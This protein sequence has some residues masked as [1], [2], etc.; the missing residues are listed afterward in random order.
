MKITQRSVE[1]ATYQGGTDYRWD[2]EVTGFGLRLYPSGR[3]AYV[4]AYRVNGRKR[5]MVLGRHGAL[6]VAQ[7]R[8][9]AQEKLHSVSKGIDPSRERQAARQA[10]TVAELGER[11]LLDHAGPKKKLRSAEEDRRNWQLHVLPRLA[12]RKVAEVTREDVDKLHSAMRAAPYAANRV[13]ALLSKAFTLAEVWGWRPDGSNPCRHVE[14]FKEEKRERFLSPEEIG[15]LGD[16]LSAAD[17]QATESPTVVA[18]VRLL[19]FTGCRLSEILTLRWEHVDLGAACLRLPDSKTGRRI[20]YLSPPAREVLASLERAEGNPYVIEG[21][22]KGEHLV[23]LEKPWRRIRAQVGLEDVRLHDLR[24]TFASIGAG[25]GLSLPL[26]GKMLGHTQPATTA[27]YAHL[28][29]DPVRRAADLVG[30][31]IGGA[32]SG[33]PGAEVLTF[34]GA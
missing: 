3:K 32:L 1:A 11:Y 24:H 20:V 34:G 25:A 4:A 10:P 22:R 2:D 12:G 28:A 8:K 33:K 31:E 14:R 7:A 16:G 21:A 30:A 23:N 27:R 15:R 17:Y 6:T 13:L 5:I 26:I 9:L 19:L 18:A 29:A